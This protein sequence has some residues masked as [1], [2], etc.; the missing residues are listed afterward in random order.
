[1][2]ILSA[3][4]WF[5]GINECGH[6]KIVYGNDTQSVPHIFIWKWKYVALSAVVTQLLSV[7]PNSGR[8]PPMQPIVAAC[9]HTLKMSSSQNRHRIL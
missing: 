9:Y 1:M 5:L 7:Q 2:Y 6:K 8:I 4:M 3:D